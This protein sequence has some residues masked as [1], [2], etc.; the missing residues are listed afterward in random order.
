MLTEKNKT[1][2]MSYDENR[3][4]DKF[5]EGQ[6]KDYNTLPIQD[7]EK[8]GMSLM[9]RDMKKAATLTNKTRYKIKYFNKIKFNGKDYEWAYGCYNYDDEYSWRMFIF[10]DEGKK[11]YNE[12]PVSTVDFNAD[13]IRDILEQTLKEI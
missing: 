5:K 1:K 8:S 2:M 9:F 6:E 3:Y 13:D 11:I 7:E 12:E 4:L 10:D